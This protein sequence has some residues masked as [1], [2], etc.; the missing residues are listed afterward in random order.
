M[1]SILPTCCCSYW[2]LLLPLTALRTF[3]SFFED[4][5]LTSDAEAR[6]AGGGTEM[7][8]KQFCPL[9]RTYPN[10]QS[11]E[12]CFLVSPLS[13]LVQAQQLGKQ[14]CMHVEHAKPEYLLVACIIA[15]KKRARIGEREHRHQKQS[16]LL[17]GKHPHLFLFKLLHVASFSQR[18]HGMFSYV[19]RDLQ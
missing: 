13:V 14:Y 5:K 19:S 16:Q 9:R 3:L 1:K 12:I 18:Y 4:F 8:E 17:E 15:N 2:Y 10:V 6:F 11:G 7:H